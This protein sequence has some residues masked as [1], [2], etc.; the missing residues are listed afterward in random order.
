M[1]FNGNKSDFRFKTLHTPN[2][3]NALTFCDKLHFMIHFKVVN[4]W[5]FRARST[6][7]IDSIFNLHSHR[8]IVKWFM[9]IRVNSIKIKPHHFDMF[10][11]S[12]KCTCDGQ[13]FQW[14]CLK[15]NWFPRIAGEN[16]FKNGRHWEIGAYFLTNTLISMILYQLKCGLGIGCGRVQCRNLIQCLWC[17]QIN[18]CTNICTNPFELSYHFRNGIK[19]IHSLFFSDCFSCCHFHHFTAHFIQIHQTQ[20]NICV[21]RTFMQILT[22]VH[23]LWVL[24]VLLCSFTNW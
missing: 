8:S 24:T 13:V 4:V 11:R 19:L 17:I 1:K 12:W 15:L 22:D 7:T 21:E 6:E 16:V 9:Y 3:S 10:E 20:H 18:Y 23:K 5:A 2:S 14:E